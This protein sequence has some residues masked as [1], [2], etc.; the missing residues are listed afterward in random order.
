MAGRRPLQPQ[1]AQRA[2]LIL[3]ESLGRV[4]VERPRFGSP[5][6][7]VEHGQVER[8][9]LPDAV[10]VVTTTFSPRPR[11]ASQASALVP[12]VERW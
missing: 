1:L 6:D 9:R 12:V 5:S 2:R 8:E 4:E 11:Q 10:P 3:R 7:L